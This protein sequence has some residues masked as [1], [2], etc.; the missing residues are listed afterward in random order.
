[1][2]DLSNISN[3]ELLF[4]RQ[5]TFNDLAF[6][7]I[8]KL[9][10]VEEYSFGKVDDRINGNIEILQVI[11]NEIQKRGFTPGLFEDEQR[12]VNNG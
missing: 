11:D 3:Q 5:H 12:M 1:M 6:L 9:M 10:G 8:C 4:D 2:K 7:A